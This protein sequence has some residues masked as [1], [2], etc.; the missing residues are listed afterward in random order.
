MNNQQG[1]NRPNYNLYCPV[2]DNYFET[3]KSLNAHFIEEVKK[4]EKTLSDKRMA[5]TDKEV[6][7]FLLTR[8]LNRASSSSA[9]DTVR[10]PHNEDGMSGPWSNL[11]LDL[12]EKISKRLSSLNDIAGLPAVCKAWRR[13]S[14]SNPIRHADVWLMYDVSQDGGCHFFNPLDGRKYTA[15]MN[16]LVSH[17]QVIFLFSKGGWIAV[18][19]GSGLF[20]LLRPFPRQLI[21]LPPS[22]FPYIRMAFSAPPTSHDCVV[23]GIMGSEDG[24]TLTF[25]MCRLHRGEA[26]RV[27]WHKEYDVHPP[28]H[29]ASCNPVFFRD[30]FFFLGQRGN[31][32]MFD[33]SI[34]SW[35]I[36]DQLAPIYEVDPE[37]EED[38]IIEGYLLELGGNL[39][40]SFIGYMPDRFDHL[41]RLDV[42]NWTWVKLNNI[43]DAAIYFTPDISFGKASA[44]GSCKNKL[45]FEL[46][47][48]GCV[49]GKGAFYC[50]ENKMYTPNF[51]NMPMPRIPSSVWFE[52]NSN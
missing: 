15:Q 39:I 1:N 36:L 3:V 37:I 49:N 12:V 10:V 42:S 9:R 51:H 6:R 4:A 44:H 43:G 19:F 31:L 52:P 50:M 8:E 41:Y 18:S 7:R 14:E 40:A 21:L 26:S 28:F 20:G 23:L 5:K 27:W 46:L 45:H 30:K 47:H 35:R 13:V 22:E 16:E 34:R 29:L 38:P 2:C 11:P 25:G 48:G 32:G 17:D 24:Y 33:P